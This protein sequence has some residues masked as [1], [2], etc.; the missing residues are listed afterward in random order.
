MWGKGRASRA[1]RLARRCVQVCLAWALSIAATA[2]SLAQDAGA[3]G[4]VAGPG[5]ID[6]LSGLETRIVDSVSVVAEGTTGDAQRDARALEAARASLTLRPGARVSRSVLDAEQ[7]RLS[8]LADVAA[9]E[10]ALTPRGDPFRVHIEFTLWLGERVATIRGML[11]EDG[12]GAFPILWRDEDSLLRVQLNGGFGLFSDGNPWF[13]DSPTFTKRN[14]LVQNP[15]V[16]ADTGSRATWGEAYVEFGLA[17]VTRLGASNVA[18][19]GAATAILPA[20]TGQDIFRDDTRSTF[21]MEKAYAGVLWGSDDRS[22]TVNLS[23]GRQNFT[24]NDGFLIGQYGSQW[25]AGPRPGIYLAPRTTHD[26]TFI[27]IGRLEDWTFTGFYLDPNEYEPLSTDTRLAGANLRYSFTD[28][29]Y[30]DGTYVQA[31]ESTMRYPVPGGVVGTRDGLRTFAGHGRW[32]DPDVRPGLWLE[33][34]LA[35][36]NHA[37]FPMSAWG[38][39]ATAGYLARTWPWTPSLSLRYSARTGDDPRTSTYERFDPLYAGGLSE[40]LEGIT[41]NK[42]LTATNRRTYRI[43]L[44]VAPAERVNLT[45]DWFKHEAE[46][47]NNLGGN[48]ALSTLASDDLGEE[49]QFVARWALSRN[50]FLLGVASVARPG[51]AIRA[52]TQG[53]SRTWS[54]LQAHV[55][56]NF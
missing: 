17:G 32:A 37:D 44:N 29:F 26:F 42:V 48:P 20:S 4:G 11:A 36:Q 13:G 2:P 3:A 22:R 34:E 21:D 38:G 54:T 23:L 35:Y 6:L 39:Y 18:V 7:V 5:T 49:L 25:N 52:A 55:Y 19:Y 24:L 40:W 45:L 30:F 27:G 12:V 1:R 28:R 8:A 53:N 51:E 41:I 14:P 56:W 33:S 10:V 50:V 16:G 15:A 9:A 31:V 46:Q 43:R 47:L